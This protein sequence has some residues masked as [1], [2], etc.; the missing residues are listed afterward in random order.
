MKIT[1]LRPM[2]IILILMLIPMLILL[3]IPTVIY[4]IA[5]EGNIVNDYIH[6]IAEFNYTIKS[7]I[8]EFNDF[9]ASVASFIIITVHNQDY[10]LKVENDYTSLIA[11]F[12]YSITDPITLT[13][14]THTSSMNITSGMMIQKQVS[15][16]ITEHTDMKIQFNVDLDVSVGRR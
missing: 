10:Q 5:V 12:I 11:E 2:T 3:F 8:A 1:N 4:A 7:S 15:L 13:L 9:I 14:T 6:I 16:T